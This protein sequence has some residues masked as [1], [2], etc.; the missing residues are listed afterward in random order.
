MTMHDPDIEDEY[1]SLA[2][3]LRAAT[4]IAVEVND[5]RAGGIYR[6]A[7][8]EILDFMEAAAELDLD[9]GERGLFGWTPEQATVHLE[10]HGICSSEG[11]GAT[12]LAF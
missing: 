11:Y 7:R 12:R 8:R 3:K 4:E 10:R 5:H 1:R 9:L 2:V 6:S